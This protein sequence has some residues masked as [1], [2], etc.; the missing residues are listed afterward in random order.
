[1]SI[2]ISLGLPVFN[3]K[4]NLQ[5]TL[6]SISKQTFQDYELIISDNNSSDDTL[7]I[8]EIYAGKDKRV[9]VIKN[10][11]NIGMLKNFN[12]VLSESNNEYFVWLGAHDVYSP[13]FLN[14]LVKEMENNN[15]KPKLIF[16]DVAHIDM[17]G[18]IFNENVNVGFELNMNFLKRIVISPWIIKGSGDMVYGLFHTK[19]LKKLGGFSNLLWA[20]VLLIYQVIFAGKI[21]KI[22][23]TLRHRRYFEDINMN[24]NSWS[25]KYIHRTRRQRKYIKNKITI[26]LYFPNIMMA[27][28]IIFKIGLKNNLLFFINLPVSVYFAVVYLWRHKMAL[29]MDVKELLIKKN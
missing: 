28:F 29:F 5:E 26:D 23:K 24:F 22:N 20:D 4:D 13:A 18:K 1:M 6:I 10:K 21:I 2:K 11:T 12:K 7:K 15:C 14:E 17:S 25:E 9:R 19:T 27:L 16:T 3:E 8:A